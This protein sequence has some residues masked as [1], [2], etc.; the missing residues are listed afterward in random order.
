VSFL[1]WVRGLKGPEPQRFADRP[2]SVGSDYWAEK[3]GRVL[4][5]IELLADEEPLPL[6]VLIH[7]YPPPRVKDDP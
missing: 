1:V 2:L 5:I 7:K 6:D 4:Q 3:S